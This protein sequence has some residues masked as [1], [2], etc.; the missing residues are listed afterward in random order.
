MGQ[1]WTPRHGY[2]AAM[3][4]HME[5]TPG[6]KLLQAKSFSYWMVCEFFISGIPESPR[7]G[8]R[9]PCQTAR[10]A[11]CSHRG[12]FFVKFALDTTKNLKGK[13]EIGVKVQVEPSHTFCFSSKSLG[14]PASH[15]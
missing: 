4:R 3:K 5:E 15:S 14:L 13:R 8:F 7:G 2:S 10:V 12:D 9:W 1:S 6:R 11:P